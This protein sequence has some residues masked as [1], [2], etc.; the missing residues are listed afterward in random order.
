MAELDADFR[1]R[2]GSSASP[3][4]RWAGGDCSEPY[5]R[6]TPG[7]KTPGRVAAVVAALLALTACSGDPGTGPVRVKWDRQTCE[8]CQMVLSDHLHAAQVRVKSGSADSSV[9]LFDD[10][11]CALSW[12]R[13]QPWAND[14]AT[15]VWVADRRTGAWLDARKAFFVSGEITPMQYGLGA[16][17]AP[18]LGALSFEGARAQ[19][20]SMDQRA[21]GAAPRGAST[22]LPPRL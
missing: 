8:R 22:E 9:H 1:R 19:V 17:P 13:D 14:A 18:Q 12:L 5:G 15:E 20:L 6:A 2:L 4:R 10:I 16:Q 3:P 7:M 21:G 11:G